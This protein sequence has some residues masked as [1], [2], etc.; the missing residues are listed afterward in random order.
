MAG[1]L[2]AVP[3]DH[4]PGSIGP[5]ELA[6]LGLG[7]AFDGKPLLWPHRNGPH[8]G[9]PCAILGEPSR[10]G[11]HAVGYLPDVQTWRRIPRSEAW[12]GWFSEAMPTEAE[13]RRELVIPS[14]AVR[15]N[16]TDWLTPIARRFEWSDTGPA[17]INALPHG[18][19][20]DDDGAWK[21]GA[22]LPRFARL[23]EIAAGLMDLRYFDADSAA[24][25]AI[26]AETPPGIIAAVLGVN[27]YVSD[28]EVDILGL[29]DESVWE[30]VRD[31]VLD[32][33]GAD[34]LKK[35]LA[36]AT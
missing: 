12:I 26:G 17:L 9:G 19:R 10:M 11:T 27:Y 15:M 21:R 22:V 20:L 16:G 24:A 4:K 7:H 5:A 34:A 32:E 36:S 1:F 3:G 25:Q 29:I 35:K 31:A 8:G 23:N 2:Y 28:I 6:R 14:V 33:A 18:Y 13:L 30:L